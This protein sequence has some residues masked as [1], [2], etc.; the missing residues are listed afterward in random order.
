MT[1]IIKVDQ[2]QTAAGATPT[3]A[4]LGINVTGTIVAAYTALSSMS[5]QTSASSSHTDITGLSITLTPKSA[6]NTIL[7]GAV[8]AAET[9][10]SHADKGIR[11]NIYRG[12]TAIYGSEYDLYNSNSA[13]QRI[14]KSP[15]MFS[16]NAASTASRTYKISFAST[17]TD[18]NANARVNNYG[19]PSTMYIFEIAG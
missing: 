14:Q 6:A 15:L 18:S 11:F 17:R 4:D 16:E 8:I 3:V 19:E 13:T 7:I 12:G 10:G 5:S 9:H 1:S 2:I